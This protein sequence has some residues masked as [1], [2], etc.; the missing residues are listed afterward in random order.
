MYT[1]FYIL[2]NSNT[3]DAR[4]RISVLRNGG[5][6]WGGSTLLGPLERANLSHW[7]TYF[8]ITKTT[9][10]PETRPDVVFS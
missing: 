9:Y 6:V 2:I 3:M 1:Q 4:I 8:S 7:T 10:I 5:W